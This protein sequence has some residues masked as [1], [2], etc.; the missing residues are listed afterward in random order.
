LYYIRKAVNL[1]SCD[2]VAGSS[3]K[4]RGKG[5]MVKGVVFFQKHEKPPEIKDFCVRV[6]NYCTYMRQM[7]R[8][9]CTKR[10]TIDAKHHIVCGLPQLH[11]REAQ[12]RSFVPKE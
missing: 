8:S 2:K 6:Q 3:P 1:H 5:A 11:L 7:F 12:P 9:V 10:N 4:G